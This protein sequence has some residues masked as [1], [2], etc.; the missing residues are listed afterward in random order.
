MLN[1]KNI[2][3]NKI[4]QA[5]YFSFEILYLSLPRFRELFLLYS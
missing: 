5:K 3:N 2:K 1:L 4:Y